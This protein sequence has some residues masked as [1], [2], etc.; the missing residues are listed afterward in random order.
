MKCTV[1]DT[2]PYGVYGNTSTSV[3]MVESSKEL[4]RV[5]STTVMVKF[6]TRLLL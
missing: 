4:V 1:F 2:A 3:W 6:F 5:S